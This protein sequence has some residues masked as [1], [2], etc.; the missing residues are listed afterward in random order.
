MAKP[1]LDGRKAEEIERAV[2]EAAFAVEQI[3][4]V[5]A[6][7]H[8]LDGSPGEPRTAEFGQRCAARN[9]AANASRVAKQLV[10]GE[11][12][13]VRPPAAQI[14]AVGRRESARVQQHIPAIGVG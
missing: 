2:L 3:V 13:E 1:D 6:D 4:A 10:E 5:G 11:R 9:Q 8:D 7:R 12:H 14:E